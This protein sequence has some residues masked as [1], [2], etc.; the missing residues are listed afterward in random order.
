MGEQ[1]GAEVMGEQGTA[2]MIARGGQTDID[3][4]RERAREREID[5]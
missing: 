5:R 4:E 3:R 2:V 1:G